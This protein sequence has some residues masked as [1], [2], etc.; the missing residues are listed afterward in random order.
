MAR[1]GVVAPLIQL[2]LCAATLRPVTVMVNGQDADSLASSFFSGLLDTITST[3]DSKDCPGVCVHTLA[4]LICYEVLEN[5]K[6]P[7]PTMR[8]CVEPPP[9]PANSTTAAV[10]KVVQT[11]PAAGSSARPQAVSSSSQQQR[12]A[13]NSSSADNPGIVCPGVC[14]A[15]RIADYCE[16]VLNVTEMCKTGLRCCVSKDAFA[17]AEHL[18]VLDRNSTRISLNNAPHRPPPPSSTTT[19]AA[20]TTAAVDTSAAAPPPPVGSKQCRGEC[21]SGLFALFCDDVDAE[22]YCPGDDSSC[23]VTAPADGQSSQ[24]PPPPPPRPTQPS[25]QSSSKQPPA[26]TTAAGRPL[27][28]CPGF[29]LLNLMAAFCERP[30]V[31]VSYT[32]TCKQGSVCCDN[33]K[34]AAPSHA[35]QKPKPRPPAPTTT[36]VATPPAPPDGRPECPGS[37]IVPYLSF[38]CFRNAEMTDVFKCRKPGTQC[39][40]SKTQI[41][42]VVEQ[43]T[44]VV[45]YGANPPQS[46]PQTYGGF[47]HRNDTVPPFRPHVPSSLQV[48]TPSPVDYSANPTVSTLTTSNPVPAKPS[49]YSKYVCGVKGTSR[50]RTSRVVGGEDADAAEWCWQ[51]ALI[52]SLNQYLCGGALIGT[53]WVLTAAHCVTNIVRSGDAIYVRVGDH[54]LTRKYGSPGAQ[55]LRVATTY[56]HH[57]HNSQTLDNDIALLKLHGQAELKDGVCLVCLPARGVSHAAGKRCT[58]TGYGLYGRSRPAPACASARPRSRCSFC[59]GG[60]A[61]NDACQGDGGGPLVCQDDG[62]FELAGL[63]SWGFGCGRIDVPGVYVKVSS[64]IG[65]I[66]QIISVNNL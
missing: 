40:A 13:V 15:E 8:C 21:V 29:C 5:V 36:T 34:A 16:A 12:P 28:K 59:A 1:P 27:P 50:T 63:V 6:C 54:D 19:T 51:V 42:E 49:T 47:T 66:N 56:I 60:E 39:C 2:L 37:C 7:S 26:T 9:L 53:Q 31:L 22:A 64:F 43:K 18:V 14:V 11:T 44:G 35:T 57:N 10:N 46:T 52:N 25:K 62:F 23:C 4:T 17:G 32:S 24:Q 61:G 58:V 38:T 30:S 3:A 41:R 48:Y 55:T 45:N 20:T 65:W 33:T